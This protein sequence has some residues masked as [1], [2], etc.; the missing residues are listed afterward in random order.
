MKLFNGVNTDYQHIT[1]KGLWEC[2]GGRM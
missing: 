2:N 1:C